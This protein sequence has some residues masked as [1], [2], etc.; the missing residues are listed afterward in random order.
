MEGQR[1]LGSLLDE[2]VADA[3]TRPLPEVTRRLARAPSLPGKAD[4][5]LGMRRS[6]KTFFLYQTLG[7]LARRGVPRSHTLYLNFEDERLLPLTGQDLHLVSDA[8]YRA[9]P[10]LR[11]E[12][13]WLLFDEIQNVPGWERFVRRMLDTPGVRMMLTGS[14]AKLLSKEIATSLRGR[15]LTTELLPF[16]FSEALTHAGVEPPKRWPVP[17]KTRSLLENRLDR[18]LVTG[19]FPEVQTVPD[20]LCPRILQEYVDV[21][22]FR[23]VVE[24]H[25]VSGTVALRQLLRRLL[26]SPASGLSINKLYKDFQSQGLSV[27]KDSLH[28]YVAYFEDAYLLFTVHLHAK[29][30]HKKAVNPRKCYLVDHGLARASAFVRAEDTGHHLENIVFVELRRRGAVV[31]YHRTASGREVD[32]VVLEGDQ[33]LQLVQVC[34]SLADPETRDRELRALAEAAHETGVRDAVLVTLRE[35]GS[36]HQDG[37]DVRI[38]PAWRWLLQGSVR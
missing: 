25:A 3:Q 13:H 10:T 17:A 37:I 30:E 18:Y 8:L 22:L 7:E 35:Q 20:A 36:A 31:A 24:R 19:G 34:A 16:G 38:E 6:G 33:P 15:C 4:V 5:V 12:E 27:A 11:S 14:S 23:D 28:A 9:H 26:R 32:F 29:S 21:V 2:L 1:G